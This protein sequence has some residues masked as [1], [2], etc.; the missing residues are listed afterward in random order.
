[1]RCTVITSHFGRGIRT[2]LPTWYYGSSGNFRRYSSEAFSRI[3]GDL[4]KD[5]SSSVEFKPDQNIE[6]LLLNKKEIELVSKGQ[7]Y[8]YVTE[9]KWF[10]GVK[11]RDPKLAYLSVQTSSILIRVT[12][13][14]I[15]ANKKTNIGSNTCLNIDN[16][17][18]VSLG[19][20]Q[21]KI[22]QLREGLT[23]F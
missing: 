18:E 7:S 21:E 12:E 19:E 16:K 17:L 8:G 5:Y 4:I 11:F 20:I 3:V 6:V 10:N 15:T 9:I 23:K 14:N 22:R 13:D 1:M 2:Q